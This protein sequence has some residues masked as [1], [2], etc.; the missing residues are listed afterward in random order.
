MPTR[1][2]AKS[3]D[4]L[5][6]GNPE[7]NYEFILH[8]E[9]EVA[10]GMSIKTDGMDL[11]RFMANPVMLL[12]HNP[13]KV[14]GCWGNVQ[15]INNCIKANA[16][17]DTDD[18]ESM[19]IKNKVDKG[20]IKGA[21][22]GAKIGEYTY[23]D[24]KGLINVLS[25]ELIETSI[26]PIPANKRAMKLYLDYDMKNEVNFEYLKNNL[27][28]VNE[29]TNPID[30]TNSKVTPEDDKSPV[31][32]ATVKLDENQITEIENKISEAKTEITAKFEN[33]IKESEEWF[34]LL[35]KNMN[36]TL[37]EDLQKNKNTILL[38]VKKYKDFYDDYEKIKVENFI[39]KAITD[40]KIGKFQKENLLKLFATSGFETVKSF[41]DELKPRVL[42]SEEIEK[43]QSNELK[44]SEERKNW[45]LVKWMNDDPKGLKQHEQYNTDLWQKL[46]KGKYEDGIK[47]K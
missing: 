16:E 43:F 41:V 30:M 23:D 42:L 26:T 40:R 12:N 35:A 19:N 5:T 45:S 20:L 34:N 24:D 2:R 32:T 8:D 25:C 11:S 29:K 6:P 13:D 38:D 46:T 28:S 1:K 27:L 36:I 21:S 47:V 9:N 17:W 15:K 31:T 4:E 44:V 37:T 39:D 10:N 3:S 18:P 33:Q 7:Q 22:I 14:L